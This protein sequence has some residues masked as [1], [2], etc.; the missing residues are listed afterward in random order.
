M[1]AFN[2]IRALS[3]KNENRR[4]CRPFDMERD[5]FVMGEGAAMLVLEDRESALERGAPVLAE[6]VAYGSSSDA[7]HL[8]QPAPD[9]EGAARAVRMALSRSGIT[10]DQID[11]IHA[12]GTA[13]LLNDRV[14]TNV[15]KKIF[16]ERAGRSGFSNQVHDRTSTGGFR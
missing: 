14:E 4:A 2:A 3:T 8:I 15:I 6:M 11:Y 7:F 12:H 9:G 5:G 10:P 13:T 16:G 1:A